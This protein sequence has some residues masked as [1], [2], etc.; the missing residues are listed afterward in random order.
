MLGLRLYMRASAEQLIALQKRNPDYCAVQ[1]EAIRHHRNQMRF[2][3]QLHR[4]RG[5]LNQLHLKVMRSHASEIKQIYSEIDN[6]C[7]HYYHAQ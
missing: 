4:E 6:A 7:G 2:M 5:A 3:A 1:M